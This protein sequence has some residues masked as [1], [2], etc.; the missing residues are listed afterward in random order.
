MHAG[1]G[2][3]SDFERALYDT[4]FF[5]PMRD[6]SV[7]YMFIILAKCEVVRYNNAYCSY[8][9]VLLYIDILCKFLHTLNLN[10]SHIFCMTRLDLNTCQIAP[11]ILFLNI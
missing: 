9:H 5:T 8:I 1:G 10:S 6:S 11:Y 4:D 2:A 3:N 7:L